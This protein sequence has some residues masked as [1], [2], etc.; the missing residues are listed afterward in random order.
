MGKHRINSPKAAAKYGPRRRIIRLVDKRR[1]NSRKSIDAMTDNEVLSYFFDND[2][3]E[4]IPREL[5]T[6]IKRN[7][8]K[9]LKA[10]NIPIP[11]SLREF[12]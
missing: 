3:G 8:V 5:L 4:P 2:D 9:C 11:E 12:A 6:A 1:R 7:V 10:N